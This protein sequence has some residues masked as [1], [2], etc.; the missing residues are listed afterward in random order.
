ME[1]ERKR[2]RERECVC[3]CVLCVL[4]A[5]V[6]VS[7]KKSQGKREKNIFSKVG[8]KNWAKLLAVGIAIKL[9][10]FIIF[11]QY[12]DDGQYLASL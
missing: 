5:F 10:G 6:Y 7:V 1:K 8:K 2:E 11:T 4:C 3:L 9:S 12:I